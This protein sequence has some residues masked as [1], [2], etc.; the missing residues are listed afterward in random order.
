MLMSGLDI[1]ILNLTLKFGF[2][3]LPLNDDKCVKIQGNDDIQHDE[4]LSILQNNSAIH[5]PSKTV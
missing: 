3:R 1:G 4:V 5:I 2:V